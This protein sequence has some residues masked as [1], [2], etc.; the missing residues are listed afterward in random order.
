MPKMMKSRS[1]SF[2]RAGQTQEKSMG[3]SHGGN[4]TRSES[5]VDGGCARG[6]DDGVSG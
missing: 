6:S 3:E 4:S 1:W 2:L 5:G